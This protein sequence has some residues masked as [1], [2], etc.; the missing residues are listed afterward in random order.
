MPGSRDVEWQSQLHHNDKVSVLGAE[1]HSFLLIYW[2]PRITTS[3]DLF[4]IEDQSHCSM[5]AFILELGPFWMSYLRDNLG[6]KSGTTVIQG[7]F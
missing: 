3:N 6:T 1:Y 4:P 7:G 5:F 2:P